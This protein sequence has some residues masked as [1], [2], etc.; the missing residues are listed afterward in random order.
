MNKSSTAHI[1]LDDQGR[2]WIDDANVKVI[3]VAVDHVS[4]KWSPEAIHLQH[5]TLS[6]AQIHA[7]LAYYYDHQAEFDT[8]MAR[9]DQEYEAARA[10]Q[11]ND[12]PIHRKLR[13]AGK[14][15]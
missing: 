10:A 11:G 2:A 15:P 9:Q 13:A 3:E 14:I 5:P 8:E 1:W 12:T 7:A 4:W 6:L